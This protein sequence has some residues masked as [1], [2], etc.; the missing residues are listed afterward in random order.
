PAKRLLC[1]YAEQSGTDSVDAS[2]AR[3]RNTEGDTRDVSVRLVREPDRGVD[4]DHLLHRTVA[5]VEAETHGTARV[6]DAEAD[7]VDHEIE[8][9]RLLGAKGGCDGEERQ[10]GQGEG[11]HPQI[12]K[13]RGASLTGR[14]VRRCRAT[15]LA[16]AHLASSRASVRSGIRFALD[17]V[18][19]RATVSRR[20]LTAFQLLERARPVLPQQLRE[21]AIMQEAP[22]GLAA[23]AVVGLVLAVDDSLDGGAT[24]GARLAV[25]PV[26]L[27]PRVER[28]DLL[29]KAVAR[30][31]GEQLGPFPEQ[32]LRR[33]VEGCDLLVAELRRSLHRGELRL[34]EDLV[35]VCV[36]D[37]AQD[38]WIG[39]RALERVVLRTQRRGELVEGGVQRL[40]SA[41]IELR[42][43]FLPLLQV[44][45]GALVRRCFG[46]A[47]CTRREVERPV[48]SLLRYVGARLPPL[49][50][51]ADHQV[52]ND[53][54][55]ALQLPD[56]PLPHAAQADHPPPLGR[57]EWRVPGAEQGRRPETDL[58]EG[59]AQDAL[60]KRIAV[61]LDLRQLGHDAGNVAVSA[62]PGGCGA[63]ARAPR[64]CGSAADR[65]SGDTRRFP[66]SSGRSQRKPART[67][68]GCA[69][70]PPE[71]EGRKGLVPVPPP[72]SP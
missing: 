66:A 57:G 61:Q 24:M 70:G 36:A 48:R 4:P 40:D 16:S 5:E 38:A 23:G 65:T 41:T 60:A 49:Q 1:P 52:Q 13:S 30:F 68:R 17:Y 26:Y 71:R 2:C 63:A 8:R 54:Q 20:G 56:D 58:L 14:R 35:R 39:Q 43:R 10:Q 67:P 19:E 64:S 25:P 59:L 72:A 44:E 22:A 9:A 29:W 69:A 42:Q 7:V 11:S 12:G 21:G 31:G 37:P 34:Q 50:P 28:G 51:A 62:T 6:A 15:N 46:E 3:D 53:E 32:A 45:G 18:S 47:Q 33:L 27:H 55:A